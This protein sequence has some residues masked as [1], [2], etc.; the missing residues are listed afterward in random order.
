MASP[1]FQIVDVPLDQLAVDH[2]NPRRIAEPELDALTRSLQ[3]Y[4]FVQPLVARAA[5]RVVVAGHQRLNV[6]P[7]GQAN[8]SSAQRCR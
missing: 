8:H 7:V 2:G 5:D 4:G 6:A 3:A 1:G